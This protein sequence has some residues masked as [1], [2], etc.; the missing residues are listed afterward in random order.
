MLTFNWFVC[1]LEKYR[2]KYISETGEEFVFFCLVMGIRYIEKVRCWCKDACF[3]C[4]TAACS[5]EDLYA[6]ISWNAMEGRLQKEM[7]SV[8]L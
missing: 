1:C 3:Y 6:W 2:C 5:D 4:G 8:L 7:R